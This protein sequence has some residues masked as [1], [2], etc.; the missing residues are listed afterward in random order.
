MVLPRTNIFHKLHVFFPVIQ[1]DNFRFFLYS[2]TFL[3]GLG[4]VSQFFLWS[5]FL[6]AL[7]QV[8]DGGAGPWAVGGNPIPGTGGMKEC[9]KRN[10]IW[11]GTDGNPGKNCGG[12]MACR[13][14]GNSPLGAG[15]SP[16][17][18]LACLEGLTSRIVP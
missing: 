5:T 11:P 14:V 10:G 9:G 8:D 3:G 7:G 15:G 18:A 4:R 16:L 17:D 12:A 1:F 2:L 13:C 6:G